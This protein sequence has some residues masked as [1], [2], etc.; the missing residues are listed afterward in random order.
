[1]EVLGRA[2]AA[3]IGRPVGECELIE[4][5]SCFPSAVR[6]QQRALDLDPAGVPT[7]TGGMAFAGGPFNNFVL[8][9]TV[10]VAE[11]L[12]GD[13]SALGMVTTV[14]G[15][16]TKPGIGVWSA[17]PDGRPP[18]VGDFAGQAA[19]ATN[20]AE[21]A[22]DDPATQDVVSRAR[23]ISATVT[24]DGMEPVHILALCDQ[25]DG[26]RTVAMSDDRTLAA[27]V[28]AQGLAGESVEVRGGEL[29]G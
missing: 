26:R 1:M 18:L 3:R 7:V 6:V 19:A 14:S 10:A 4:V 21:V 28:V 20:L 27:H 5:Y 8:Q 23:V 29:L 25:P 2:A 17:A 22:E 12:R 11:R 16:L 13:P 24:Y 9:S 15:L